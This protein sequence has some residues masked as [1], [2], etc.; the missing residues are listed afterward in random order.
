M[1]IGWL[2]KSGYCSIHVTHSVTISEWN[3]GNNDD[4]MTSGDL[5]S[6]I[7]SLYVKDDITPH[8]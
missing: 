8:A 3:K 5:M 2:D 4:L 6:D 1:Q 7:K